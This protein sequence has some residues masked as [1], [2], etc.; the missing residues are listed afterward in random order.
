MCGVIF[1][2]ATLLFTATDFNTC[3]CFSTVIA[4]VLVRCVSDSVS[5]VASSRQQMSLQVDT[6]D[7][8]YELLR[9]REDALQQLEVRRLWFILHLFCVFSLP[10][11]LL[12]M[13]WY[14]ADL[15]MRYCNCSACCYKLILSMHWHC[16]LADR[17]SIWL[18]KNSVECQWFAFWRSCQIPRNLGRLNNTHLHFTVDR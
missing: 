16:W 10:H 9:E 18:C 13:Y 17:K 2:L 5:L 12:H 8:D 7:V 4:C 15:W 6:S 3:T 14:V 11:C 1:Q